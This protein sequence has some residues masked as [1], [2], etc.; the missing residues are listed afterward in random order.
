MNRR[1]KADKGAQGGG[2]QAGG[3]ERHQQQG[4]RSCSRKRVADKDREEAV[5][6]K[7]KAEQVEIN[8]KEDKVNKVNEYKFGCLDI[9]TKPG[10]LMY[11]KLEE[12]E[13]NNTLDMEEDNEKGEMDKENNMT[14]ER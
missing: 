10:G 1:D 11:L 3:E 14:N 2:R 6:N 8:K 5:K 12:D 4:G 7:T 13:I 9:R